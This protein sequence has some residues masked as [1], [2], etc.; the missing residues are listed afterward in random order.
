MHAKCSDVLMSD[1]SGFKKELQ[2]EKAIAASVNSSGVFIF[3][4]YRT[5]RHK[6]TIGDER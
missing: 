6:I 2:R 4:V 3:A 1:W 5:D